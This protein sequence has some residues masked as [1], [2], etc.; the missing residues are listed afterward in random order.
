LRVGVRVEKTEK[1]KRRRW[2]ERE[3]KRRRRR[4]LENK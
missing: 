1:G 3:K 4:K 2:W